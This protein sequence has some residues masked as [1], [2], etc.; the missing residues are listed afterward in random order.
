MKLSAKFSLIL[1]LVSLLVPLSGIAW[2]IYIT[3][4]NPGDHYAM[5]E[6]FS[7]PFPQFMSDPRTWTWIMIAFCANAFWMFFRGLD[8][9]GWMRGFSLFMIG[10][11]SLIGLWLLFTLM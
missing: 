9:K 5:Q 6:Q 3:Q 1:G 7:R 2:W 8:E 4:T 11:T 10:F